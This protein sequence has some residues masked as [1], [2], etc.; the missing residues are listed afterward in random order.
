MHQVLSVYMP[1]LGTLLS[2]KSVHSTA[3]GRSPRSGR[4]KPDQRAYSCL[5]MTLGKF[6]V[7]DQGLKSL[8][9]VLR[10]ILSTKSVHKGG[11]PPG[12]GSPWCRRGCGK[13]GDAPGT[14]LERYLTASASFTCSGAIWLSNQSL[15]LSSTCFT[16]ILSTK[17]V[18]IWIFFALSQTEQ[19]KSCMR[20][21]LCTQILAIWLSDEILCST[22][23]LF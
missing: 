22:I 4:G 3:P 23:F 5:K 2:T 16:T 20:G 17:N 19:N 11:R 13:A 15:R 8:A 6:T 21:Y 14:G 1:G 12:Q 10:T 18:E 7:I 9:R